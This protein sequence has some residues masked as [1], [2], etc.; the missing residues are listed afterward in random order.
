MNIVFVLT[1]R[2]YGNTESHS[3]VVAAHTSLKAA[4]KEGIEHME[5]RGNKYEPSIDLVYL[6]ESK[7]FT[8]CY[9]GC[10]ARFLLEQ[11]STRK[12]KKIVG[13]KNVS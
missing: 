1:M 7:S 4:L 5:F 2:R 6:D 11:M 12:K 10:E 13:E 3:Y 9:N 8:I